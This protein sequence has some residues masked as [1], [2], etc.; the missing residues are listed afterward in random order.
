MGI[1]MGD[2]DKDWRIGISAEPCAGH[3]L[4]VTYYTIERDYYH[5]IMYGGQRFARGALNHHWML[6]YM[7]IY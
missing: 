5:F 6:H 4:V 7:A 1:Y 3:V 2:V